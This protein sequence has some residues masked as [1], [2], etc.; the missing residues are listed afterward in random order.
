MKI[1]IIKIQR[2]IVDVRKKDLLKV[3]ELAKKYQKKIEPDTLKIGLP[4][5]Q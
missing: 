3:I 5:E 1:A 2:R 4:E